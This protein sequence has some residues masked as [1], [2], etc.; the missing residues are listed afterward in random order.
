FSSPIVPVPPPQKQISGEVA[1]IDFVCQKCT[2]RTKL[3]ANLGKK[4]PIQEGAIPFPSTNTF[5][6]PHCGTESNLASIRNQ[7]EA[8][9]KKK[10]V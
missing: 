7:I 9:T 5:N 4:R 2:N 1:M 3:Q 10:I 8:Q 6:C